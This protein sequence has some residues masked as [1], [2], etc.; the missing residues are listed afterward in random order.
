ML[1]DLKFA[2]ETVTSAAQAFTTSWA[3]LGSEIQL[4]GYNKLAV[5]VKLDINNTNNP[6]IRLLAK[7]DKD[8]ADEYQMVDKTSNAGDVL[9]EAHYFEWNV[10]ADGNFCIVFDLE[11]ATIPYG[12]LQIQCGTVGATAGE[13]DACEVA[14]VFV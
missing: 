6:R 5:Y 9:V 8:G 12:Q 10:D 1:N 2:R 7:L 11:G 4:F 14:K 13:I 3:D